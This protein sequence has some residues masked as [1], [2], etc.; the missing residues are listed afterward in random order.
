MTRTALPPTALGVTFGFSFFSAASS[1]AYETRMKRKRQSAEQILDNQ[2]LK[3][4]AEVN[5]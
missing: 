3:G 1:A 5:W 4:L 2:A